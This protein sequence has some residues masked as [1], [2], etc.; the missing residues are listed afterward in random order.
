MGIVNQTLARRFWP[1]QSPIG[2]RLGPVGDGRWIRIVGLVR[3]SRYETA[4]EE[5][6]A[7]L[8]RPLSQDTFATLDF[9]VDT[10]L[11]PGD[12]AAMIRREVA[13]IDPDQVVYNLV[14]LDER[15]GLGRL[16]NRALAWVSGVLGLAGLALGAIGTFGLMSFLV[17][18][19]RRELGIR[20]ALGAGPARVIR[21]TTRRGLKW[22]A[23]GVAAGLVL[24]LGAGRFL[25]S[26]F[27]DI[28]L[29]EPL[30]LGA[31]ALL[32]LVTV[33]AACFVPARRAL[34]IDPATSLHE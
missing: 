24:A 13:A 3:D 33:Y 8:Y 20:I 22:A 30:V 18:S 2:Q 17:E 14:T 12:A 34:R 29:D 16:P 25:Q 9:L 27:R 19:R 31:V 7:V 6:K 28:S 21:W 5:P 15:I 10:E 11:R 23:W 26:Q 4:E 1:D 32:L